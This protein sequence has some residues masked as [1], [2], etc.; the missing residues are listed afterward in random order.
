[1]LRRGGGGSL[2]GECTG[3]FVCSPSIL[4][5]FLPGGGKRA[6][7]FGIKVRS[8]RCMTLVSFATNSEGILRDGINAI[9][10]QK[11]AQ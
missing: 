8:M 5:N 1:M 2:C 11:M 6:G 9:S 10:I 4:I 3:T 7:G